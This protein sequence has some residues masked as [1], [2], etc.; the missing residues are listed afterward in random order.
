MALPRRLA[1]RAVSVRL[2]FEVFKRDGFRCVYCGATPLDKLL[3]VDHV[4]PVVSGGD[5]EPSNLVTACPDCNMGKSSVPLQRRIVL[6]ETP[7]EARAHERQILEYLSAQR[8]VQAAKQ[9][10]RNYVAD[11]WERT[12]GPMNQG[13]YDRLPSLIG[14]LPLE[15]IVEAIEI[16]GARFCSVGEPF[17]ERVAERQGKYFHGILRVW[18]EE[19]FK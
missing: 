12:I 3:H 18:R 15:K 19:G 10:A 13:M 1:R 9:K 17:L 2:R 11:Y 14:K 7:A 4:V 8:R 5:N 6:G 16:T